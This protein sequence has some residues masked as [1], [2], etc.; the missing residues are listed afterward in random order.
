MWRLYI[1]FFSKKMKIIATIERKKLRV[2]GAVESASAI[3]I[4][5]KV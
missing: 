1:S 4:G 5:G 3:F 2:K